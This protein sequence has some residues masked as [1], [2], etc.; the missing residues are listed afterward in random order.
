MALIKRVETMS[1][2]CATQNEMLFSELGNMI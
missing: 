1:P 2:G